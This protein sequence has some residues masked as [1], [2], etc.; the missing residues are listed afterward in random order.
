MIKLIFIFFA[1]LVASA[2]HSADFVKGRVSEISYSITIT[3]NI[4]SGDALIFQSKINELKNEYLESD[5]KRNNKDWKFFLYVDLNSKGGNL[6]EAMK[7]GYIVRNYEAQTMVP[8][9]KECLSSCVFI[10]AAGVNR[11][12]YGTV[13][14]HRPYFESL[15]PNATTSE[16]KKMREEN[17]KLIKEYFANMD[18]S[19]SIID[20]MMS[21]EP[22]K[23]KILSEDELTKFRLSVMDADHEEKMIAEE[24]QRYNLTSSVYRQRNAITEK[25][26]GYSFKAIQENKF[27][28]FFKCQNMVMLNISESEYFNREARAKST[29]FKME[30]GPNRGRCLFDVRI[31]GK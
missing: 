28:E 16:I 5:W 24:A 14:I 6:S 21:I 11:D 22:S 18:V 19:D 13:G 26:C 29:C 7:I 8:Y 3:G 30:Q 31:L 4:N 10:L 15:N 2:A 17:K 9:K 12:V 23:I 1:C 27:P 20:E 25:K